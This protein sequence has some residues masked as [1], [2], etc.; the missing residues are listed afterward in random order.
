MLS[1]RAINDPVGR[2]GVRRSVV[3]I[4]LVVLLAELFAFALLKAGLVTWFLAIIGATV[5]TIVIA[6]A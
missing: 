4:G 5:A 3:R 6:W 2:K 1:R